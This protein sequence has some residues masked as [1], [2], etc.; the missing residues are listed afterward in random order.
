ML[1]QCAHAFVRPCA[2]RS[3]AGVREDLPD[4]IVANVGSVGAGVARGVRPSNQAF[5]IDAAV[6]VRARNGVL[7]AE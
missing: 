4:M 3:V 1:Q 5:L 7:R 6:G 2:I